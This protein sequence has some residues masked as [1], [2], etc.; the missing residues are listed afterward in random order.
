MMMTVLFKRAWDCPCARVREEWIR[1]DQGWVRN[2]FLNE[3][4]WKRR[5]RDLTEPVEK[6]EVLES[7]ANNDHIVTWSSSS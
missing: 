3:D 2:Q 5:A 1:T 7:E 6:F 4:W